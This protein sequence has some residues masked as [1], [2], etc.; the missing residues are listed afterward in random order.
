M[1]HSVNICARVG[2]LGLA[3]MNSD[4]SGK[5]GTSQESDDGDQKVLDWSA[6]DTV[7]I[8]TLTLKN[9]ALSPE[10]EQLDADSPDSD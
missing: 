7:R 10:E 5:N 6:E 2:Y 8:P 1:I 4:T 9:D 3:I